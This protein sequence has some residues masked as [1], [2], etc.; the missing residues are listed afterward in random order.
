MYRPERGKR[1]PY[2]SD[3]LDETRETID[4]FTTLET[5]FYPGR[6]PPDHTYPVRYVGPTQQSI[7]QIP[8]SIS[9]NQV[10]ALA[11]Q[12]VAAARQ[13]E[14]QRSVNDAGNMNASLRP[15]LTIDLG[16]KNI[17]R[18]PEEVVYIIK[19]EIERLALPH[20]QIWAFPHKFAH[21]TRLRYLNVRS[22]TLREFPRAICKLESLEILDLSRNRLRALPEEI[23]GLISLKVF[24]VQKNRLESL[25]LALGDIG[26]LQVLKLEGNPLSFLPKE[27]I[28]V[29]GFDALL[30]NANENEKDTQITTQV[31]RYLKKEK[32]LG[33]PDIESGGDSGEGLVQTPRPAKRVV[34][35]RFPVRVNTGASETNHDEQVLTVPKPPPIPSRSHYRI[36]SQ[37][38]AALRRPGVTPLTNGNERSRSNSESLLQATRAKRMG[39]VTRKTSDLGTVDEARSNPHG[40]YRGLSHGSVMHEKQSHSARS[41]GNN[42]TH[43][44]SPVDTERQRGT[45][46]RRLSSLPEH[47]RE[48]IPLAPIIEGAKGV[49]YGLFQIHPQLATLVVLARRSGESKR[50]SLERVFYNASTHVEE[51]DRALHKYNMFAEEDEEPHLRST[52]GVMNACGT[53]LLAYGQ[54]NTLLLR[55][56]RN[57][58]RRGDQRYI[59]TLS[60]LAYGSLIE[61][62]NACFGFHTHSSARHS[63]SRR[64]QDK[65]QRDQSITPTRERPNPSRRLRSVTVVQHSPSIASSAKNHIPPPGHR[66]HNR[67]YTPTSSFTATPRSAENFQRSGT[68]L[69]GSRSNTMQG[70]DE[71][72]E[73]RKF[74]KI[75]LHLSVAYSAAQK[76][77]PTLQ[78]E[79]I[80]CTEAARVK[81]PYGK[82]DLICH[83]LNDKTGYAIHATEALK[84]RLSTVKLKEPGVRVQREFWQLSVGFIKAFVNMVMEVRSA[85]DYN[86]LSPDIQQVLQPVYKAAKEAGRLIDES[87]WK[88]IVDALPLLSYYQQLHTPPPPITESMMANL[89]SHDPSG[90]STS[91]AP[92]PGSYHTPLPPTPLSA[93]LGPAAQA[94]VP[95]TPSAYPSGPFSGNVFER[96][97]SLLSMPTRR[98]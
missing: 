8:P 81:G 95:S 64:H 44:G 13:E 67:S 82:A 86:L 18:I 48:S 54:V 11:Q 85:R 45:F 78:R 97:E 65:R 42:G 70:P 35:G 59:R 96:A 50:T 2:P 17:Q 87:P 7:S 9:A 61:L 58:V 21:C 60:L 88:S 68:S 15:G 22:N 49:L 69:P 52:E 79:I 38:T 90:S 10:I 24:S 32:A 1:V 5:S 41:G 26:T 71:A 91:A 66:S 55:D 94:T 57:L 23:G 63:T 98:Q 12:A 83:A 34:S 29:D 6:Y 74:E 80:R 4:G 62:R 93:A 25:P 39:M 53:S 27:V 89:Y 36:D 84:R 28:E 14:T 30:A 3:G 77:L 43:S 73:E 56:V 47:K 72:E 31:K 33:R 37:E 16:H 92:T 20:N 76:A 19:D 75:F 40:H 46:V 51:L